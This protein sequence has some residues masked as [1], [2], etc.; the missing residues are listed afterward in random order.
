MV[1]FTDRKLLYELN[2]NARQTHTKL[3]K[4]MHISKQVVRYRIKQLEKKGIIMSYHAV[5]DWRKLE[6][7]QQSDR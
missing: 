5:I 6:C 4:K 1:D 3:A 7:D 2:W